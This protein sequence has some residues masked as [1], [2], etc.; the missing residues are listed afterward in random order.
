MA[1]FMNQRNQR[2]NRKSRA[3]PFSDWKRSTD[4]L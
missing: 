2:K 4:S 3:L 1:T